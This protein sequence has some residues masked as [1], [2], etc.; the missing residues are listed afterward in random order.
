MSETGLFAREAERAVVAALFSDDGSQVYEEL[1]LIVRPDDFYFAGYRAVFVSVEALITSGKPLDR[2]LIMTHIRATA[3]LSKEL[4]EDIAAASA[5]VVAI[6]NI[7]QYAKAIAEK[8]RARKLGTE[9]AALQKKMPLIGGEVSADDV[10]KELDAVSLRMDRPSSENKLLNGPSVALE[11]AVAL[12]ESIG[13]GEDFGVKSGLTD[14]D[15][16]LCGM[17]PGDLVV[18]A[19]R[20]SMGKTAFVLTL[21]LNHGVRLAEDACRRKGVIFGPE[22]APLVAI[23]SLEMQ[24]DRLTVRMMSNLGRIPHDAIRKGTM[25]DLEWSRMTQA[26]IRYSESN[27]RIDDDS[28]LTPAILRAKMRMLARRVGR[29]ISLC[30]IDYIQLMDS[31][32]KDPRS[33]R[34]QEITEISR[35]LKKIAKEM[36]CPIVALSQL[37][38]K[39]EERPNKRP[40]MSDIRESGAIEQD[41]DTI[42][43]LYRD[44]YYNP[45]TVDK[46]MVELIVA[47][48]RDVGTGISRAQ[49]EGAY[50]NFADF[51]SGGGSYEDRYQ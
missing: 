10:I 20:P 4:K 36:E 5:D 2:T 39:V 42:I 29:P 11:K 16:K 25:N 48:G 19:G 32:T 12:M 13:T 38:R 6:T 51:T 43:F 17:L 35:N 33:N 21:G 14:L 50:Q 28:T 8:S 46:G 24:T 23:F 44:E 45:D 47:K 31:D 9:L 40:V 41:A 34:A 18:V 27:I 3:G 26:M 15:A 1:A 37:N 30:I 22:T 7:K 49:F